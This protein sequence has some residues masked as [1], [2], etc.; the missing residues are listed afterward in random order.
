MEIIL[1]QIIHA[2]S[3]FARILSH[4]LTYPKSVR[5]MEPLEGKLFPGARPHNG[6]K[7]LISDE[8]SSM[9]ASP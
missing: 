3:L 7:A 6:G 8:H 2:C 5:E 4:G 1:K 9:L